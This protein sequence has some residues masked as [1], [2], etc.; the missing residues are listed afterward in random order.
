MGIGMSPLMVAGM[1]DLPPNQV[2]R[3]SA[4]RSLTNQIS[5]AFAV[6]A[7]GAVVAARMGTSATPTHAVASYNS[8]FIA[9]SL[10]LLI[11]LALASRL[12]SGARVFA[13]EP[14]A[15]LAD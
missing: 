13:R 5:G 3:G 10:S 7:L 11:A 6:A 12:P 1:S 4:V 9:S 15:A 2:A 14:A 8:A